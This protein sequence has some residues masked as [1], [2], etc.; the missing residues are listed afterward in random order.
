MKFNFYFDLI[1]DLQRSYKNGNKHFI[2]IPQMLTFDH[3]C[4]ILFP[5]PFPPF[6]T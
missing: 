6:Y 2:H 1:S 5:L 3:V 4:F